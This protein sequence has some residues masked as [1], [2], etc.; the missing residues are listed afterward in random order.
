MTA[1]TASSLPAI[2]PVGP[3]VAPVDASPVTAAPLSA[4]PPLGVAGA[5]RE[6]TGDEHRHAETRG[7]ITALM[8]GELSLAEFAR[9]L[10]QL[11]PVYEALEARVPSAADPALLHDT[12]VHRVPALRAS[13]V[14][15]GVDPSTVVPLDATAHY[16][17]RIAS[18]GDGDGML[19]LAH[20]YTRYLGDLSGGQAIATMM[21][22]HYGASAEQLAFF[23]FDAIEN[24]VHFKRA[25]R[26]QLDALS[27]PPAA[28]DAMVAEA[29]HAFALNAAVFDALD[30]S[31]LPA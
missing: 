11:L 4:A 13:L 15:L 9:Y 21:A 12:A 28:L 24:A 3:S 30:A 18:F 6:A 27:L 17:A 25:Y 5:L 29:R 7:Y 22:R 16:A 26:A 10:G 31:R 23:R 20:H 2:V 1:A 14:A 8:Q 19:H